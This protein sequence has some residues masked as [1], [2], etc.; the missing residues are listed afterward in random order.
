MNLAQRKGEHRVALF[1]STKRKKLSNSFKPDLDTGQPTDFYFVPLL[2]FS[3]KLI[4][5]SFEPKEFSKYLDEQIEMP[6]L[7][8]FFQEDN[9]YRNFFYNVKTLGVFSIENKYGGT[10]QNGSPSQAVFFE[11]YAWENVT[12]AA[13]SLKVS[14]KS[15]RNKREQGLFKN[16]SQ[17]QFQNFDGYKIERAVAERYFD[18]KHQEFLTFKKNLGF[19]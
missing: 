19:R 11:N 12:A 13:I 16:I 7:A 5:G 17:N 8:E 3:K 6:I 10:P 2:G 9:P 14:S 1:D 15:I 4:N 18:Y